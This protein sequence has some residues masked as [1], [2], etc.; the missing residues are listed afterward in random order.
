[1]S[2]PTNSRPLAGLRVLEL[3]QRFAPALG[4]VERHVERL[5]IELTRAGASVEVVT[6]DLSRDQPLTRGRFPAI[7]GPVAVRRHRATLLAP[8][9]HGSGVAIPGMV[10][11]ALRSSADV[12][13]AHAF[14]HFPLW[15]G[16]LSSA[17]RGTRLIVTPHSDPGSGMPLARVWSRYVARTS[18]RGADRTVA[19]SRIEAEWLTR[20]GVRPERIRV[21]PPGIDV[22]EFE[23]IPARAT[24]ARGPAILFVGRLDAAQKGLATLVRA[25]AQVPSG[26]RARLRMVGQDWGGLERTLSLA[27]SLGIADRVDALGAVSRADLLREYARAELLV[28]PSRFDSFP[29]VVLEA[30]AAGLPVVATRVGGVP[31]VVEEGKSGLLVPPENPAALAE[32][33]GTVLSDRALGVRFGVEGRRRAVRFDWSIVAGEY[34][35]LFTE[36][37]KGV[38]PS[39]GGAPQSGSV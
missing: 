37:R 39:R 11:D 18:V 27:R 38:L 35:R 28:L 14:G 25:V 17:L 21:I 19:L 15:V 13:H 30:M 6:S 16:Q 31:E 10:L 9:P 33:I 1:M 4:G 5:A 32:A 2:E 34:V 29:V 23:S 26:L 20:L 22:A 7:D 36:V 12:V 8:L 24:N 3:T